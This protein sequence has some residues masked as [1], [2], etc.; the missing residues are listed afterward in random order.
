[1]YILSLSQ[2]LFQHK[3]QSVQEKSLNPGF[4]NHKHEQQTHQSVDKQAI[5]NPNF[6]TL[7]RA[8]HIISQL[9]KKHMEL[10]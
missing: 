1:M 7:T 9:L 4:Q 6:V 2:L 10:R 8:G 3:I 5:I